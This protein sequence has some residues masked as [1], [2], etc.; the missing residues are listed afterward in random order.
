[1]PRFV[2][3]LLIDPYQGTITEVDH[4]AS[5]YRN[6][7]SLLSCE[8]HPVDTFEAYYAGGQLPEGDAIFIDESGRLKGPA[9]FFLFDGQPLAGMALV[10][11][12]DDQGETQACK[13]T[14]DECASRVEFVAGEHDR[15]PTADEIKIFTF[16]KNGL[17]EVGAAEPEQ[18]YGADPKGATAEARKEARDA[19]IQLATIGTDDE[20]DD[21]GQVLSLGL[22]M[23][24]IF[25]GIDAA[26]ELAAA[27]GGRT[28]VAMAAISHKGHE[29]HVRAER[30]P[31]CEQQAKAEP[32][33]VAEAA[34]DGGTNDALTPKG[35][36]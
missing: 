7:Y 25:Q 4:D 19:L 33:P 26:T 24:R 8:W 35:G 17:K 6:I 15:P 9:T 30:C 18:T 20:F 29:Y 13:L 27:L 34:P 31:N 36:E 22:E 1:M 12:S 5:D 2:K 32:E 21:L 11:G 16:D 14:F 10:L 28:A 3:A 23:A